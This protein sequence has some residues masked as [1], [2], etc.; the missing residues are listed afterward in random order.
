M[1]NQLSHIN[2]VLTMNGT[3]VQG[4]SDDDLP[5][6]LPDIQLAEAKYGKDGTM[7]TIGSGM[8]GGDVIVRLLPSS[9][10]GAEWIKMHAE[11]QSGEVI[12]WEGIWQ[13]SHLGYSTLLRGGV[14]T[15]APSG[16]HPGKNL[17][18]TFAFEE[19]LPQFDGANFDP[20]PIFS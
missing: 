4:L 17:E 6:E 19:V 5:V 3:R 1:T 11:I 18:F 10:T 13:D 2:S 7:Y 14:L 12:D 8:K 9:R 15:T 20:A 16:V